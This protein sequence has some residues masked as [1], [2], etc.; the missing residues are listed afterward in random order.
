MNE[1]ETNKICVELYE[2]SLS[3]SLS[4]KIGDVT[5]TIPFPFEPLSLFLTHSLTSSFIFSL[6]PSF[7]FFLSPFQLSLT[8]SFLSFLFQPFSHRLNAFLAERSGLVSLEEKSSSSY[9]IT[10]SSVGVNQ[11]LNPWGFHVVNVMIHALVVQMIILLAR[12]ELNCGNHLT[13]MTSLFFATHP[14]H[15]EAVSVFATIFSPSSL[16]LLIL[17]LFDT[18]SVYLILSLSL[19]LWYFLFDTLLLSFI[20]LG[21]KGIILFLIHGFTCLMSDLSLFSLFLT[22][23]SSSSLSPSLR[24]FLLSFLTF[25]F[26]SLVFS[27]SLFF[28]VSWLIL[29]VK[30][31]WKSRSTGSIFLPH[32]I[33]FSCSVSSLHPSFRPISLSLFPFF[34]FPCS[35]LIHKEDPIMLLFSPFRHSCKR[36]ESLIRQWIYSDFFHL[37]PSLLSFFS[38]WLSFLDFLS[39][40]ISFFSSSFFLFSFSSSRVVVHG[41]ES[42]WRWWLGISTLSAFLAL[43]SKETGIMILPIS[44]VY[45]FMRR[46]RGRR[47]S[48][49]KNGH[50]VGRDGEG[51]DWYSWFHEYRAFL[52]PVISVSTK[53]TN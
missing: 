21:H 46:K 12:Y 36:K 16:S 15:T 4:L 41:E 9:S 47:M 25:P 28:F 33:P 20:S 53:T 48:V 5:W 44:I 8:N 40:L 51:D 31:R 13:L 34:L 7:N 17:S 42:N 43:L 49:K 14:I 3:L 6:S 38:S 39:S 27:I 29:G 11:R 18:F 26:L 37:C 52:I 23:F 32:L 2:L 30:Y 45:F 35:T 24:L 22:L 10:P 19:S 50:V 1:R